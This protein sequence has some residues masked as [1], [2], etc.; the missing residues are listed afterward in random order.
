MGLGTT[1]IVKSCASANLFHPTKGFRFVELLAKPGL[2]LNPSINI[3]YLQTPFFASF[4]INQN[5]AS[6]VKIF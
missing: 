2:A 1:W 5:L 3:N 4:S 6:L